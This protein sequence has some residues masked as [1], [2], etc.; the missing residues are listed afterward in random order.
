MQ[1]GPEKSIFIAGMGPA[2]LASAIEAARKGYE[3]IIADPRVEMIRGQRVQ[4]DANT[5]RFLESL[6]NNDDAEDVQFFNRKISRNGEITVKLKNIQCFLL[7]KLALYPKITIR[8]GY[9]ITRID[10]T[11]QQVTI[12]NQKLNIQEQIDFNHFVAADGARHDIANLLN[13]SSE[14][15]A[16]KIKYEP[17]ADEYQP[18][19]PESGTIALTLVPSH[20]NPVKPAQAIKFKVADMERLKKYGW[21]EPF[22]PKVYILHNQDNSK[23]FVSG[24]I[25]KC[26]YDMTDKQKQKIAL[27]GWGKLMA[28]MLY[29]YQPSDF[30]LI[31]KKSKR[32]PAKVQAKNKLKTTVFPL[33]LH[34]ACEASLLLGQGG[35]FTLVGD[36][37]KNANFFFSHGVNDAILDAQHFAKNLNDLPQNNFDI[38]GYNLYQANQF[39]KHLGKLKMQNEPTDMPRVVQEIATLTTDAIRMASKFSKRKFNQEIMQVKDHLADMQAHMEVNG[40]YYAL[41]AL[42]TKLFNYINLKMQESNKLLNS[43]FGNKKLQHKKQALERLLTNLDRQFNKY[44]DLNA[45]QANNT[46]HPRKKPDVVNV[47]RTLSENALDKYISEDQSIRGSILYLATSEY[48]S[49]ATY[50]SASAYNSASAYHSASK[51]LMQSSQTVDPLRESSRKKALTGSR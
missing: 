41:K 50:H 23:L 31:E 33:K 40:F 2:G 46:E 28:N 19:H 14:N 24:E 16:F 32:N 43:I 38:R 15:P 36:A 30:V 1:M 49:N 6:R 12:E 13:Q 44:Y 9:A 10:P 7:R 27:V 29:G 18:R 8:A 4:I 48:V 22:Y 34:A 11:R 20:Q 45:K 5:V 39:E 25:P 26:I 17:I 35:S 42:C 47:K 37:N 3:V 21:Q 51:N